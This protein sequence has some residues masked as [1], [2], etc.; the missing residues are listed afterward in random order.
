MRRGA[1]LDPVSCDPDMRGGDDK[2]HEYSM[3]NIHYRG[4]RAYGE[5]CRLALSRSWNR[6]C[7]VMQCVFHSVCALPLE[8]D[9]GSG[10]VCDDQSTRVQL[11][12]IGILR[13][14]STFGLI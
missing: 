7:S 1:K 10:F 3:Y 13:P 11:V 5:R 12:Q 2:I 14:S 9:V 4:M 6:V 8:T